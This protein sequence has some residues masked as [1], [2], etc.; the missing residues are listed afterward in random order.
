MNLK[1]KMTRRKAYFLDHSFPAERLRVWRAFKPFS[2]L[3]FAYYFWAPHLCIT[4]VSRDGET[5]SRYVVRSSSMQPHFD[6]YEALKGVDCYGQVCYIGNTIE[7][8][9]KVIGI[10]R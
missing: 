7:E 8:D 9:S 3:P 1:L 5:L 4:N 2:S 6:S 10:L